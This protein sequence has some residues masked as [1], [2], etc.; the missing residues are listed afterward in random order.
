MIAAVYE[1]EVVLRIKGQ[2]GGAIELAVTI[3]YSSPFPSAFSIG[4]KDRNSVKPFICDV[5]VA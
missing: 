3:A 5:G 4:V 1:I 2:S